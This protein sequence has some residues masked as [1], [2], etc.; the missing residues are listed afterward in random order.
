[1]Q[2]RLVPETFCSGMR[3]VA[4]AGVVRAVDSAGHPTAAKTKKT[5]PANRR[6]FV[7]A[8]RIGY[9]DRPCYPASGRLIAMIQ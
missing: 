8:E 4:Q 5:P 3:P 6:R 1:M 7:I 2:W 9:R